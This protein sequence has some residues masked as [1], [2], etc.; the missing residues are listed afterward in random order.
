[1]VTTIQLNEDVKKALDRL[2]SNKETYEDIII[3]MINQTDEQKRKFVELMIEGAKETAE[4]SLK[5]GEIVLVN[6]EPVKGSEQGGIRPSLVVQN[7]IFNKYSPTTIVA[8]ITSK[9]FKKEYPTNVFVK[10]EDSELKLDSTILLNQIKT[11]DKS[12]IIKKINFLDNFT[13]NKVNRAIKASL[14][15]N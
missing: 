2:K 8:P 6:F 11:I 10:K 12:R 7:D 13:M 15:L 3:K 4:E 5:K 14:D 9:L 1:M